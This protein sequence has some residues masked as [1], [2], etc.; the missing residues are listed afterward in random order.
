MVIRVVDKAKTILGALKDDF[1]EAD[2]KKRLEVHRQD[3]ILKRKVSAQL[4]TCKNMGRAEID[5]LRLSNQKFARL[6]SS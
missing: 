6:V 3:E 2:A 4:E 5:D 1:H